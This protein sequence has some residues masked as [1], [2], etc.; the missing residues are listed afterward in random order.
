M[1]PRG[2]CHAVNILG[3]QILFEYGGGWPSDVMKVPQDVANACQQIHGITINTQFVESGE[4]KV[5]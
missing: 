4:P 3:E 5:R 2:L 1:P